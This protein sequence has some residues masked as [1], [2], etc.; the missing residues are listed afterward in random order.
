M[1]RS[2]SHEDGGDGRTGA[3][4]AGDQKVEDAGAG[5]GCGASAAWPASRPPVVRARWDRGLD[6]RDSIKRLGP[7]VTERGRGWWRRARTRRA[8]GAVCHSSRES[9]PRNTALK[10]PARPESPVPRACVT[11]SSRPERVWR[12]GCGAG[13]ASP[14][15]GRGASAPPSRAGAPPGPSRC[16]APRCSELSADSSGGGAATPTPFQTLRAPASPEHPVQKGGC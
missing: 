15:T 9:Q 6:L 10:F 4:C 14:F 7:S 13:G 3:H 5:V 12:A 8:R 16:P 1:G 2:Q 11:Q